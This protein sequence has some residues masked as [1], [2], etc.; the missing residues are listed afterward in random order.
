MSGY[1]AWPKNS[2]SGFYGLT[3][4]WTALVESLNT[5]AVRVN[6]SYGSAA[7]YN[8]MVEKLGFTTLTQRDSQ[9][10]GNMG[11]GGYDVGVTTEE[12]AAAYAA[13]ANDGVYTKP[14]T[15]LPG[16]GLRGECRHGERD[17]RPQRHEGDYRL[18]TAGYTGERYHQ[19]YRYGGILLRHDHRR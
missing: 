5:C 12:M 18:S 14:R 17:L 3:T 11:L 8:Y 10:S 19:R 7:S 1:G 13:I 16:G 9:Q 4:V 2:H 15:W 6:E